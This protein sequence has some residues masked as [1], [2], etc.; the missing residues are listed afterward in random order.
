M[1]VRPRGHSAWWAV[2]VYR[3][4]RAV[5][6]ILGEEGYGM[7]TRPPGRSERK[8]ERADRQP[9]PLLESHESRRYY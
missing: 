7:A 3:E 6:L 2:E 8:G 5:V 4:F 9:F 1:C